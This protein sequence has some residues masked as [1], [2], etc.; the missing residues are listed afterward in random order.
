VARQRR[1][2]LLFHSA[3]AREFA[4]RLVALPSLGW[5]H[6][7][8]VSKLRTGVPS[9]NSG[10]DVAGQSLGASVSRR[11]AS[12]DRRH[13]TIFSSRNKIS[14]SAKRVLQFI[15]RVINRPV[16]VLAPDP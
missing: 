10:F 3:F 7:R 16:F 13:R 4:H 12:A 9:A 6:R 1:R 14:K 2:Q 5:H 8:A 11:L 15:P